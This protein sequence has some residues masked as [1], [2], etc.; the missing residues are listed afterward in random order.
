MQT[1]GK[2]LLEDLSGFSKHQE[3]TE[4]FLH[5]L[6]EFRTDIVDTWMQEMSAAIANRSLGLKMDAP[7]VQFES[8]HQLMKVNYDSRLVTLV[9]EARQLTVLGHKMPSQIRNATEQAKKFMRQ[10][11]SLE[12]V[13][14]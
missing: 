11:K 13:K 8:G 1:T 9:R 5:D 10:A 7:V 4:T 14:Y 12:Q 2:L 6:Q 3:T